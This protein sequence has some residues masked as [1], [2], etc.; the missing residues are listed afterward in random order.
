[1][2]DA[3]LTGASSLIECRHS[4][5]GFQPSVWGD[6]FVENKPMSPSEL[7]KKVSQAYFQVKQWGTQG[8][9]PNVKDHMQVSLKSSGYQLLSCCSYV[10]MM[11]IIP[12]EIFHWVKSFPEI[13]KAACIICRTMG[14]LTFD[15]HDHKVNHL[16]IL[17]ESYMEEYNY[18]KEEACKKL[19]EMVE[20]AWK[21]LNQELLQLTNIPLSLVRPIINLSRVIELFYRDKDNYTHPQGT[22]R[23]NIKLVMLKPIFAKTGTMKVQ[24]RTPLD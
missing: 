23:D 16:A 22:M 2:E 8:Y 19:L 7:M 1:M 13:V 10:G 15:E 21:T 20:N 11:E 12:E 17:M 18:T 14:D 3:R 5:Q 6:Y 4:M 24:H 9:V